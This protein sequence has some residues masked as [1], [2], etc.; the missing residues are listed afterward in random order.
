MRLFCDSLPKKVIDEL[1]NCEG[2]VVQVAQED[3]DID[4]INIENYE[5]G[6]EAY[7]KFLWNDLTESVTLLNPT[8][9]H[10]LQPYVPLPAG[11]QYDRAKIANQAVQEEIQSSTVFAGHCP[12]L[13]SVEHG[14]TICHLT[15]TYANVVIVTRINKI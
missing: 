13:M 15:I 4:V 7:K 5:S 12:G 11:F 6:R 14:Q 3:S 2:V 8:F 9:G 10:L 1:R